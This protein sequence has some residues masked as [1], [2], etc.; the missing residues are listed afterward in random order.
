MFAQSLSSVQLFATPWSLQVRESWLPFP[1]PRDILDSGIKPTSLKLLVNQYPSW[2]QIINIIININI[3][4]NIINYQYHF[5]H[6]MPHLSTMQSAL[7][8][9]WHMA[10]LT[11]CWILNTSDWRNRSHSHI[12]VT[13][14]SKYTQAPLPLFFSYPGGENLSPVKCHVW[15]WSS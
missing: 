6:L 8:H 2:C 10:G 13:K 1:S 4:F 5:P 11:E 14:A 12:F 7:E 3:T 15:T 9:T